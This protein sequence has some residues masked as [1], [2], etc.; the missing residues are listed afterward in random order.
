M[1]GQSP[2]ARPQPSLPSH[3]HTHPPVSSPD[4]AKVPL[5]R[6]SD[7][8]ERLQGQRYEMDE[9]KID[10]AFRSDVALRSFLQAIFDS[11][12]Y[13]EDL[14]EPLMGTPEAE[15]LLGLIR[16]QFPND[17]RFASRVRPEL[18]LGLPDNEKQGSK[19]IYMLF[20][21]D[22]NCLICGSNTDHVGLALAHVRSDIGHRPYHCHCEK[23]LQSPNPRRFYSDYLMNDHIKG[24]IVK[25][26]HDLVRR[27]GIKRHMQSKHKD[28]VTNPQV[29][30]GET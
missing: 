14:H 30:E 7:L 27:G 19:S 8:M 26:N 6:S 20:I 28:I 24:Q 12:F 2:N 29:S 4:P 5:S 25:Q 21:K 15:H 18:A 10:D 17:M 9:T 16:E 1:A 23:C 22:N 3:S 13:Q 11:R